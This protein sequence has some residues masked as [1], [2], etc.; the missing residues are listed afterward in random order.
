MKIPQLD[1]ANLEIPLHFKDGKVEIGIPEPYLS[2][3]IN[4]Y[5]GTYEGRIR[6]TDLEKIDLNNLK[7]LFIEDGFAL[8]GDVSVQFRRLSQVPIVGNVRTPWVTVT[9]HFVESLAVNVVSSKLSVSHSQLTLS[10][11]DSWY[12]SFFDQF[13]LPYLEKDVIKS[14][15]E[16]I[17]NFNGMT[18]EELVLKYGKEKLTQ[19]IGTH[20]LTENRINTTSISKQGSEQT[21][22]LASRQKQTCNNAC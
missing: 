6:E 1:I 22:R 7:F 19:K 21:R 2:E 9:G 8:E 13:V 16:Q 4:A 3:P 15:N 14:V 11:T 17:D 10:T 18:I 12:K 5:I 20:L